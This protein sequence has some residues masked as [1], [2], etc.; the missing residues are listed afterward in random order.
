[1]VD[2]ATFQAVS[3]SLFVFTASGTLIA[4][5]VSK[6]IGRLQTLI[7]GFVLGVT[8]TA[9]LSIRFCYGMHWLML[10]IYVVRCVSQ[11]S[12][13]PQFGSVIADY[14]PKSTRGRWKALAS[15]Q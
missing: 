1:M 10:T 9:S 5:K 11:W 12:T 13:G 2:P 4:N 6:R 14:T 7:I 8:C 3:A 15:V